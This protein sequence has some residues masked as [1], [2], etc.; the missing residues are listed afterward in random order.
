MT[1]KIT[2]LTYT[3][4]GLTLTNHI[5]FFAVLTAVNFRVMGNGPFALSLAL[6][7]RNRILNKGGNVSL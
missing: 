3:N 4:K 5:P 1:H 2:T 6:A 7:I